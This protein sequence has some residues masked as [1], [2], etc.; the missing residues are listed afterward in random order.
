MKMIMN[1]RQR[2]TGN[3]ARSKVENH[4]FSAMLTVTWPIKNVKVICLLCSLDC[5]ILNIFFEKVLNHLHILST[6][7]WSTSFGGILFLSHIFSILV[8]GLFNITK[9]QLTLLFT[10][11]KRRIDSKFI[12]CAPIRSPCLTLFV[13]CI[14]KVFS[15]V[16]PQ[17]LIY[18]S[19]IRC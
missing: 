5:A 16:F 19:W 9:F 10:T 15:K 6:R 8:Q 4:P 11:G 17:V 3:G 13:P 18:G 1:Q 12:Q 2:N 14:W 7:D